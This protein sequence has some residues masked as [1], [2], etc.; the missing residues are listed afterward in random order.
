MQLNQ[1][2]YQSSL[3][4]QVLKKLSTLEIMDLEIALGNWQLCKILKTPLPTTLLDKINRTRD[5]QKLSET[6]V[7]VVY[8]SGT[9]SDEQQL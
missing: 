1:E 2:N 8:K 9:I 4:V 5:R 7:V 6:V 3:R